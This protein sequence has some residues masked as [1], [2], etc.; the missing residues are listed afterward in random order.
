MY[1]P[2]ESEGGYTLI[3]GAT[4]TLGSEVAGRRAA[5]D[6]LL[7]H[8]R[9]AV[10]LREL[11]GPLSALTDVKIWCRDLASPEGLHQEFKSF[12]ETEGIRINR[13]VHAAGYLKILPLRAFK[14]TDTMAIYSVNVFSIIEILRVLTSKPHRDELHSVVFMSALFSRFGDRGNAIYS[15]AKGALNSLIKGLAVEFPQ[16][17]FNSLILG[18]VRTRMTEHLFAN[19][20]D[21]QRFDRYILGTG[22][23]K[24][25]A[26]A[27]DFLL[28]EDLWMTG[29]EMFLDGGASVSC[30]TSTL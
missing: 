25:V 12:L 14:L 5:T 9:D 17:R 21:R 24:N 8:G 7:L 6:K 16:A 23:P 2:P 26:D 20:G 3:T 1:L 10:A 19:S 29:Q 22:Q 11:A 13:V 27:V 4:S 18:A 15:S 28:K 30:Q